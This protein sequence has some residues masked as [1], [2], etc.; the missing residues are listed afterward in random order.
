M[1]PWLQPRAAIVPR[2]NVSYEDILFHQPAPFG[3]QMFAAALSR[4]KTRITHSLIVLI[5]LR[6]AGKIN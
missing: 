4:R 3:P 6:T 5:G 2:V 1:N